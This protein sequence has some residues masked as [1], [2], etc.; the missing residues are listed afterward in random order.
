MRRIQRARHAGGALRISR[1]D[2]LKIGGTGLAGAALLGTAG[3]GVFEQG[4][5]QQGGG[6]GGGGTKAVAVNLGDTI[7]DLDSTTTT[8]SVSSDV[9]LNVMSGLYRLDPEQKPV[10]DIAEGVEI[11][12]DQLT[13][14]FTL[15]DAKW[16]NGDPVTAEDFRYAWLR[17]LN[18]DTAGQYA[19]IISSFIEGRP[20]S[21]RAKEVRKTSPSRPRTTRR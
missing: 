4:G 3:C 19:Y 10:P 6:G 14:T 18:P 1:R 11:S 9:L 12:D 5:G 13:Y 2:F 8:D 16:S 21:T 17:A 15:R 7:R 20:S